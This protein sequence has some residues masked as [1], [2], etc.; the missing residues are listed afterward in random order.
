M[1]SDLRLGLRL[2]RRRPA[3]SAAAILSLALG[4]GA[5]TAIFSVLQHVVADPLPFRD[6]DRLMMV[7]ETSSDNAERWVA[8]A[9]FVDWRREASA[10]ESLAAFDDFFP[11]LGGRGDAERLH[12]LGA[13]GTLF[14]TLGVEAALGRTL[15]P[16]DDAADAGDVAVLSHGLWQRLFGGA[17]DV[18]GRTLALDSR[19]YTIVG[20]M[21][22]GFETPLIRN[23]D[24]WLNGERGVPRTFPFGGDLSSVRDS[25]IISVVGRLRPGVTR[26]AAQQ[27][28]GALM[29]ELSRRYPSTNAGLGVHIKPLHEQITGPV[30]GLLQL[31]QLT[32]ALMLLIACANVAHLLLGSAAGRA[33]EMLTRAALGA[34][35]RRLVRQL[36]AETL[37]LAVPGGVLGVAIAA[38]TLKA[39]LAAAPEGLPRIASIRLDGSVLAFSAVLTLATAALFGLGPAFQLARHGSLTQAPATIRLTAGRSVR[40]WHHALVIAELTMA[41][42][43]LVGASLLLASFVASQRVPLGFATEGR[44][45]ADLSLAPDR[46]LRPLAEGDF[47]IDPARK[48]AFVGAVLEEVRRAPGV[49]A[50]AAS[51]TSPLTGAPNRGIS[52]DRRPPRGPGLEESADFQLVTPDYFRALGVPLLRGRWF[53][54]RDGAN[55]TPVAVVNQAFV[56]AYLAGEDPIGRH[57]QFGGTLSHEIVGVVG[58]MRYRRLESPADPA[59]YMPI[60][61]NNERWPFLSFTVWHEGD[62][63]TAA[64]LLRDAIRAADPA[65]AITRV[66]SFDEILRSSLAARRFNTL[67]VIAF[68]AAALLLAAIGTYGVMAYAVS[69]RT[70]EL[71]LRAALGASPGDLRRLLLAQAATLTGIAVAV[72]VI[73][74][75]ALAG[76]LG[77]LLYGVQPREPRII[78][79][80]ATLLTIVALAATMLPSRRAIRI[81]PLEAL[82]EE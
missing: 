81:N 44:T 65:Q 18:V 43:L 26:E 8:P 61:Q 63:A 71:G 34:G 78:A 70:R 39:L 75:L 28:L 14:T 74:A 72:G 54:D 69:V 82:R 52:L 76:L 11:T 12:A 48:H 67:L 37:V 49:R 40:R 19:A 64:R 16:G 47:H 17:A 27:E 57:V 21:P 6:P 31:L 2:L 13:S 62:A 56:N 42:V 79:A 22:E 80:V 5:N 1:G 68:A 55:A 10:F 33:S 20:V 15:Q 60:A 9:N 46:Y 59:F 50:A 7:W 25:H 3:L 73:A 53:T 35:R 58:D 36:L 66:R 24:L 23:I 29:L 32:V 41:Q 45:A 38:A 51:F 77:A 30:R 4:I